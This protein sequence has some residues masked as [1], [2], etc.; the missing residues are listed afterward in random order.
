[1]PARPQHARHRPA[2]PAELDAAAQIT[3]EDVNRAAH[4]FRRNAPRALSTLLD[5]QPE[6]P[7]PADGLGSE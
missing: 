4:A 7:A 6:L 5:A 2:S 3:A 1:V